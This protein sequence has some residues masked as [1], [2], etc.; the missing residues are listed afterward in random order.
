MPKKKTPKPKKRN[1]KR[2]PADA[3]AADKPDRNDRPIGFRISSAEYDQVMQEIRRIATSSGMPGMKPGAYAKHA[4][5]EHAR[6]RAKVVELDVLIAG[7]TGIIE[8]LD[9]SAVLD[10]DA[11]ATATA[12]RNLLPK[13]PG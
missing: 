5:L 2:S 10:P 9:S 12:L 8:N 13:D 7:V 1:T 3:C 4:L 11:V 6:L